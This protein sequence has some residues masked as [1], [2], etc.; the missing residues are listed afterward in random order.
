MK[1]YYIPQTTCVQMSNMTNLMVASQPQL[2]QDSG[3]QIGSMLY[4]I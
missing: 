3:K 2:I 4:V 1:T